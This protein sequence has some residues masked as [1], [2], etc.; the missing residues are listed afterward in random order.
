MKILSLYNHKGGVSKT[1]TTFN[2]A[3][4]LS[5]SGKKVLIVDADPQ[6]NLTEIALAKT[7]KDLDKVELETE[8]NQDKKIPG[9]TLLDAINQRIKGDSASINIDL[10]ETVE[11]NKNLH[12]L[13]GSV[14]LSSIED[15]LSEAHLQRSSFRTNLMRTYVC[16]GDFLVRLA[17]KENYD[18]ILIDVGPSSG[19]LTRAFFLVCDAFF[20]P[21][22]PDRFNVQAIGTLTTI[23]DRWIKEHQQI[24]QSY[25]E[26]G[27]PVRHGKPI[28]LG[29]II[30]S[31]KLYSGKPKPSYKLWIKRLPEA[32]NEKIRPMLKQHSTK[33]L[34][35]YYPKIKKE[36]IAAEIP[37]FNQIAPLMQE[38]GKAVFQISKEDTALITESGKPWT[39]NNWTTAQERMTTYKLIFKNLSEIIEKI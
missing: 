21:A 12:L 14:D 35:L 36:S 2:L 9:T 38:V 19:A 15:D 30:Q 24:V 27:L 18:Y 3:N 5:D 20:I 16:I 13:R 37:D 22:A 7:L 1:T 23:V 26:F 33:D 25:K 17:K 31:F 11:I 34:N 4:Y 6:C 28:F 8:E 32:I 39:G 10:I 29:A